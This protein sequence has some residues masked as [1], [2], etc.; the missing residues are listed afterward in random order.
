MKRQLPVGVCDVTAA[1]AQFGCSSRNLQREL[2]EEGTSFSRLLDDTR[3]E[4]ALHYLARDRYAPKEVGFLL[5]YSELAAF[6]RAFRRWT[7][8]TPNEYS[9]R[10]RSSP[11][12][13]D[14]QE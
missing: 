6:H 13:R 10:T 8:E 14:E 1:A 3:H 9:A 11:P 7:G 4:L 5:G 2:K 12:L